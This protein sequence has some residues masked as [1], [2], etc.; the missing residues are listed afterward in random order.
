[1]KRIRRSGFTMSYL[2]VILALMLLL[3]AMLL[4]AIFQARMRATEIQSI[5]NLKQIGLACHTYA[6]ANNSNFPMGSDKNNYSALATLL[7]FIELQNVYNDIDFTKPLDDKANDKARKVQVKIY[8]SPV[9]PVATVKDDLGATNYLFCA[10]SKPMLKGNNGPI[11]HDAPVSLGNITNGRGTSNV[12]LA[13]ETLK[14]DNGT[15]A[16]DVKRQHVGLKKEA[17]KDIKEEAG[18]Q[19]WKDGKNI[20]G[21]RGA[22]WMDGR[23]LQT[24]FTGTRLPNAAEPDVNCEGLGGLSALRSLDGR[25][26]LLYCDGHVSTATK[27]IEMKVWKGITDYQSQDTSTPP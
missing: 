13:G 15:K 24:T 22:S 26:R 1:M 12:I 8:L 9:D 7:P 6:D 10:G 21:D 25:I 18:V 14:G 19:D 20:V 27:K 23:F 5:N 3:F 4:P 11:S 2:V 17:L 16:V